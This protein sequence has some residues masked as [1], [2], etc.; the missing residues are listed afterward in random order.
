MS[1]PVDCPDCL[2]P[3]PERCPKHGDAALLRRIE[4]C[5]STDGGPKPHS[6]SYREG[7]GSCV[8]CGKVPR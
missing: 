4:L 7:L 1:N 6:F 2:G 5:P 8:Y 3:H